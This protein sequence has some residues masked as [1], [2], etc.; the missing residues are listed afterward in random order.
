MVKNALKGKLGLWSSLNEHEVDDLDETAKSIMD[1]IKSELDK[2]SLPGPVPAFEPGRFLVGSAGILLLRVLD[3]K[4]SPYGGKWVFVDGGTNIFVASYNEL[5]RILVANRMG[6]KPFE[7][8]NITGPLHG[9]L[10]AVKQFLPKVGR[11]DILAILDAG[12]YNLAM[13]RPYLHPRPYVLLVT[14]DGNVTVIR[15]RETYEDVLRLDRDIS[16]DRNSSS[17]SSF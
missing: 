3:L 13:L 4:Q 17:E 6:A 1:E 16:E 5:H 10:I 15:D 7:R 8:V 9:D 2:Y 12:A 11:E 14:A